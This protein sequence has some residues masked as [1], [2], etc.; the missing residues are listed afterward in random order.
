MQ[1]LEERLE[2]ALDPLAADGLAVAGALLFLAVVVSVVRAADF[3]PIARQRR[4]AAAA[5]DR[6]ALQEIGI[7]VLARGRAGLTLQA[8]LNCREGFVADGRDRRKRTSAAKECCPLMFERK[9]RQKAK[10]RREKLT[11]R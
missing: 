11:S 7:D 9:E 8:F 10:A 3:G 4:A 1:A 6:P 2:L 5:Y